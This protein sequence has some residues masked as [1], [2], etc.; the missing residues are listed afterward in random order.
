MVSEP[1]NPQDIESSIRDIILH[2]GEDPQRE[3]LKDTP[4]PRSR[5]SMSLLTASKVNTPLKSTPKATSP[6]TN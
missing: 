1:T 2:I 4:V 3:G 5:L 6:G